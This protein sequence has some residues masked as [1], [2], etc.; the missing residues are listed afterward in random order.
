[1]QAQPKETITNVP[2]EQKE[3]LIV[4][5][6][7]GPFVGHE[8]VN[9][10]WEAVSLLPDEIVHGSTAYRLVKIKVHVEYE[11]VDKAVEEIWALR[12]TLVIH[13]GVNGHSSCVHVEK[14]AY[15]NNFCK[16]DYAGKYLPDARACL[17]N[18]PAKK[19]AL[20]CKLNV[21]KIV[22]VVTDNCGCTPSNDTTD[23]IMT[24][25]LDNLKLAKVSK[26]VGNYLCGY[27]YLKSL[28]YDCSRTLFVHVP[29]LDKPFPV[30]KLS[31]V[32]LK[33]T[34]ECLRQVIDG[35]DKKDK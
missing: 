19:T 23:N 34:Q 3:K 29:P 32:V 4:V 33:I 17:Q 25:N 26:D 12:P 18:C 9:A 7:F 14:L 27:I 13:C 1:M 5:T 2:G 16:R 21:Q 20:F 22:Q 28:D 11:A 35:V 31:D 10:S 30:E 6:G 15:N 24:E 8:D